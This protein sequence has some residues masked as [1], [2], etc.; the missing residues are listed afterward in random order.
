[1]PVKKFAIAAA[2]TVLV[3][4]LSPAAVSAQTTVVGGT[5]ITYSSSGALPGYITAP[6]FENFTPDTPSPIPGNFTPL[7][8][9]TGIEGSST[10]APGQ[11]RVYNNTAAGGTQPPSGSAQFLSILQNGAYTL[12]F[13]GNGIQVLSF[14]FGSLDTNNRVTL[15][16]FGGGSQLLTSTGI[17][18]S[19]AG[20]G[21]N[22]RVTYDRLGNAGII[23]AVFASRVNSFE[24]DDVYIA[25]P[26]PATWGMMILGF[27]IAGAALRMRRRDSKLARA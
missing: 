13:A 18:G 15:N 24:L 4:V 22:G 17:I 21:V 27:G 7:G 25:A 14:A 26:E 11:V 6:V 12:T 10:G 23:S 8:N 5:Q 20:A 2:S 3:G 1:M 19:L 9:T 16:F